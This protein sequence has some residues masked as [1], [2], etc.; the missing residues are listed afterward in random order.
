MGVAPY[1]SMLATVICDRDT[2]MPLSVGVF[3]EW[4]S[5]KSYF[6]GLL[7]GRID[8]V[9]TTDETKYWRD[10]KQISFNAWHYADSNLWASLGDEIFRQLLQEPDADEERQK[11]LREELG[12]A[13]EQRREL[14]ASARHAEA[15]VGRLRTQVAEASVQRDVRAT[16]LLEAMG[17]TPE[18]KKGLDQAWRRLGIS[19]PAEQARILAAEVRGTA[20]E[21]MVVR[22]SLAGRRGVHVAAVA[23]L[24]LLAVGVVALWPD[25]D[26]TSVLRAAAAA[27]SGFLATAVALTASAHQGL[28]SLR[29]QI[30]TIRTNAAAAAD[31]RADHALAG[32]LQALRDAEAAR[33][34]A[35]AQL[36]T[37]V[38]RVGELGRELAELAPGQRLYTF[39]AE[40]VAA[41]DYARN[42][43]LISTIR[44]DFQ[45]LTVL[46]AKWRDLR[47]KDE[48]APRPIDRIVL[49]IDDLD[50]C[51]PRQ[52]VEVLQA[53]HLLLALDLFVVIVGVDPRWLVRSLQ[54]QY[55]KLLD[56]P[57][58]GL[59][60]SDGWDASPEDYLEKIFGVPFILPGMKGHLERVLT[61]IFEDQRADEESDQT[62]GGKTAGA[63]T[64]GGGTEG[65]G[66][67]GEHHVDGQVA[68]GAGAR[69]PDLV[70]VAEARVVAESG[71]LVARQ[72]AQGGQGSAGGQDEGDTVAA[73]KLPPPRPLTVPEITLLGALEPLVKTPR[74][75]KRLANVY[76]MIRASKDLSDAS[77]FMGTEDH[78]GEYQAVV[79]LLGLLSAHARLLGAVLDTPADRGR[80]GGLMS[81]APTQLWSAFVKGMEPR[82]QG[83]L[84][85]NDIV[86]TISPGDRAAWQA[87]ASGLQPVTALMPQRDLSAVQAWASSIRRFSFVMS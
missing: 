36:V 60:V 61:G 65:G 26:L 81:R 15:K 25:G 23:I 5:G 54:Q 71:S 40:R 47:E 1:V 82:Q 12:T 86:A 20:N 33:D 69:G 49:Y 85:T 10:I 14:E 9:R 68:P 34:L 46:M 79:V 2:K 28:R 80:P 42:L 32:R 31:E 29:T 59:G 83:D 17:R 51:S 52:V 76:R 75:A 50:R 27:V 6:M 41:G 74:E 24:A 7:R 63:G 4:G 55:P 73:T 66:S 53:V 44:K 22:R 38:D 64:E 3:G 70:P 21:A 72:D 13:V 8:F 16:D 39:L 87:L 18:V 37:V 45:E 19:D 57:D 43:G 62:A 11:H 56:A 77:R 35:Q 78:P 58:K 48:P 84:W 67:A 30:D